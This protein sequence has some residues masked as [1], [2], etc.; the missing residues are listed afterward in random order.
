ML[1]ALP[2][3]IGF[4]MPF[5]ILA[6]AWMGGAWT[7]LPVA[8]L[9]G[10][11]PVVDALAGL[12]PRN[13]QDDEA[14]DLSRNPWFRA[15][16]WAWVPIQLALIAWMLRFVSGGASVTE[17]LGVT[18]STGATTGAI[19]ITFAHELVHRPGKWERALGEVLLA[20]VS[21]THFAIEHVFG[22]H[23][24]VATPRDPATAR[25]GEALYTFL[26]RT[27]VGGLR[28]AWC[29]ERARLWKRG[30]SMRSASNR[31]VRYVLTQAA[32]YGGITAMFGAPG[33]IAVVAQGFVAVAMLETI[34]YIEHYGLMRRELGPDRYEPV[35]PWH[36]W[37]SC[38]RVSNWILIN[39]AR[40]SDHHMV[41]SK[42]YQVLTHLGE[43]PQLPAGYGTMLLLALL[44]PLW[45]RVMD[46]RVQSWRRQHGAVVTA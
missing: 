16:T 46:P 31:F 28:S 43:A 2:H 6:A 21:Y 30:R 22:H 18:L 12:N 23:R 38:H 25:Y 36:S 14:A 26:P 42:R 11:V 15:I 1:Q 5:I 10:G 9:Y 20:S 35:M 4:V 32:V 40:H 39:L 27:I 34:N 44:P 3:A 7:F 41:A 13:P 33:V 17:C 29:L 24:N 45:H 37:N 8:I 19:G